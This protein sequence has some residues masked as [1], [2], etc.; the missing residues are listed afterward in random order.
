MSPEL[1]GHV[2]SSAG[3]HAASVV[4]FVAVCDS[5]DVVE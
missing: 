2:T 3:H 4:L 5:S 1:T